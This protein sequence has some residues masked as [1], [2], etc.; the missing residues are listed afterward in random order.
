MNSVRALFINK[1]LNYSC[2]IYGINDTLNYSWLFNWVRY[3]HLFNTLDKCE[4]YLDVKCEN[5]LEPNN[6]IKK[7]FEMKYAQTIYNVGKA[8]TELNQKIYLNEIIQLIL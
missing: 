5:Y 6:M 2:S 7:K 1:L 8:Y 4:N 3:T